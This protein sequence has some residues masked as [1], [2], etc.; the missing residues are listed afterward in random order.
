MPH[1]PDLL[2]KPSL[3]PVK[4]SLGNVCA[5]IR[6][7]PQPHIPPGMQGPAGTGALHLSAFLCRATVF[8]WGHC[9]DATC[10]EELR[11]PALPFYS[12]PGVSMLLSALHCWQPRKLHAVLG[13][14]V[15]PQT[16][17]AVFF[18]EKTPN[19]LVATEISQEFP[20]GSE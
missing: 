11:G 18:K 13:E 6:E 1:I 9:R 5:G 2:R 3:T 20:F 17:L 10:P 8:T 16:S 19:P 14:R 4:R 12:C 7:H 15:T